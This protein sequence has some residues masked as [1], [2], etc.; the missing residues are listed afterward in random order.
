LSLRL[1]VDEDTQDARLV[2][3]LRYAGHDILTVNEAG[4]PGQADS[5]ILEYAHQER[6]VVLTMNCRDFLELH[7]AGDEHA[8]IVGIYKGQDPRKNMSFRAISVALANL[9][10]SGWEFA[11]QFVVLNAWNY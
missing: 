11:G 9:S 7:D 3:A 4:L 10:A 5:V 8:G 6:R 1:L 2:S